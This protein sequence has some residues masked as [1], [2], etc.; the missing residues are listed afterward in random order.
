MMVAVV[1]MMTKTV[2]AATMRDSKTNTFKIKWEKTE[3]NDL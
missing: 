2:K 3:L 1:V